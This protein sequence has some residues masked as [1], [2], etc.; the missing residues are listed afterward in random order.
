MHHHINIE[1]TIRFISKWHTGSGE[2]NF[3]VHR[4]LKKDSRGWPY[5][6]GSTFKGIVRQSCEKLSRTLHFQEPADP[7]DPRLDN[8]R[9]F[10]PLHNSLSP[11]DRLFGS[12]YE[13][14]DLFFRDLRLKAEPLYGW[15]AEQSRIRLYRKLKTVKKGALFTTQ[16]AAP[17]IFETTIEGYHENLYT[18]DENDPPYAYCLL[19]A[20]IKAIDRMGGDKSTGSGQVDIDFGS[21]LVNGKQIDMEIIFD[22]LDPELYEGTRSER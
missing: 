16:Y 11:V 18:F 20:G 17:M 8:P 22:Y 1:L 4:L 21:I 3:L 12:R 9:V 7:H 19:I 2:G 14:T 13:G 6:P 15:Q 5:I 10:G